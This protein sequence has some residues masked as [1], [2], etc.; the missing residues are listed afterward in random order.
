M[1]IQHLFILLISRGGGIDFT[2]NFLLVSVARA[3]YQLVERFIVKMITRG[4]VN[5]DICFMLYQYHALI[6]HYNISIKSFERLQP[7]SRDP[8]GPFNQEKNNAI[9]GYLLCRFNILVK[10]RILCT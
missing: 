4:G 8:S 1:D 6:Y 9:L 3:Q 10:L 5:Y 7:L 2:A